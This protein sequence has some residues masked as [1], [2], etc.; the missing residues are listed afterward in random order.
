VFRRPA[1]LAEAVE[2]DWVQ[3]TDCVVLGL[4]QVIWR[5]LEESPLVVDALGVAAEG[6]KLGL[7]L[8]HLSFITVPPKATISTFNP[9]FGTFRSHSYHFKHPSTSE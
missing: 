1:V 8:Q 6:V 3:D 7:L 2:E 5:V 9:L 4:V